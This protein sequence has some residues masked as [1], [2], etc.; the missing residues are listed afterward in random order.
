MSLEMEQQ[1]LGTLIMTGAGSIDALN[2]EAA[3]FQ[4]MKH[5]SLYWLVKEMLRRGE[6][7]DPITVI[8]RLPVLQDRLFGLDAVYIQTV[9]SLYG[10]EAS[11]E[12]YADCIREASI[13]RRLV[14]AGETIVQ[15]AREEAEDLSAVIEDSRKLVDD[16]GNVVGTG[17]IPRASESI[18][19]WMAS[20]QDEPTW[21][22]TPWDQLN[23]L[24]KGWRPGALHVV[25]ARPGQGKTV[26]GLQAALNLSMRGSVLYVSLEMDEGELFTRAV[27]QLAH[28]PAKTLEERKWTSDQWTKIEAARTRIAGLGIRVVNRSYDNITK[29]RSAARTAARD[30]NLQGIVVDYLQLMSSPVRQD[31]RPRNEVVSEI[32]RELKKLAGDLNVPVIA[33]SQLNRNS[34]QRTDPI[35]NIADLRESGSIEQDADTVFLMHRTQDHPDELML[36]VAKNRQGIE[37]KADLTFEGAYYQIT[38]RG[39][40]T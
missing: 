28:V 17:G 8:N 7:V 10:S 12:Y 36:I 40:G 35:P 4:A 24:V 30:G 25:G 19:R 34:T 14:I 18:D 5:E 33:L 27:S 2:L 32:S 23:F 15:K 29:I 26:L 20:L 21:I 11:A 6:V 37:G 3:D 13:R 38:E 9:V 22:P 39:Y 16:A 31:R 1:L